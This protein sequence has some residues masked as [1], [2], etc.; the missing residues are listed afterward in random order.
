MSGDEWEESG[1]TDSTTDEDESIAKKNWSGG[2]TMIGAFDQCSD[3]LDHVPKSLCQT[4]VSLDEEGDAASRRGSVLSVIERSGRTDL[5]V[6]GV[7]C[8]WRSWSI[9]HTGRW[10]S[11]F[12]P[13]LEQV[14]RDHGEGMVLPWSPD[15][16]SR[17][18]DVCVLARSR[19][20]LDTFN[21][22]SKE[23]I[24]DRSNMS[25]VET[26]LEDS[27]D[28][29]YSIKSPYC[30]AEVQP[31]LVSPLTLKQ[32]FEVVPDPNERDDGEEDVRDQEPFVGG[33]T[34]YQ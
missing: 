9:R 7:R 5:L 24:S 34:E 8:V 4:V 21:I 23:V 20:P 14:G 19:I 15:S 2:S 33:S 3:G 17:E 28:S 10:P 32:V 27:A 31:I 6:R 1:D 25:G 29:K 12:R 11:T 18:R 13:S 22:D 26:V 16:K 30:K